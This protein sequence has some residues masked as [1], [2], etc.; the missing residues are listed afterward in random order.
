MGLC[1]LSFSSAPLLSGILQK[2]DNSRREDSSDWNMKA[3]GQDFMKT[4]DLSLNPQFIEPWMVSLTPRFSEVLLALRIRA[5]LVNTG[6]LAGFSQ[7]KAPV[8]MRTH[9]SSVK[10][11][12]STV[13]WW[14]AARSCQSN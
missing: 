14:A 9:R 1:V 7:A 3:N 11:A 6:A 13:Y 10:Y 8:L 12:G 2:D 5:L 4:R